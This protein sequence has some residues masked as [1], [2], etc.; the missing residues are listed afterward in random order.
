ML[1][2]GMLSVPPDISG[3]H[4]AREQTVEIM[5]DPEILGALYRRGRRR[6]RD[7]QSS[8]QATLKLDRLRGVL[9]VT[10]SQE[11]IADVRRQLECVSGSHMSVAAAVWAELMRTRADPDLNQAAIARIQHESGCRIHIERSAQQIQL[12]GPKDNS[13]I[14]EQLLEEL[15]RMCVEEVVDV[16]CPLD[17]G[18]LQKL[19]SFAQ[20]FGVTLQVGGNHVNILGIKG[21]VAEAAKELC[22]YDADELQMVLSI[23]R[24]KSSDAARLAIHTALASLA[25]DPEKKA[26][27]QSALGSSSPLVQNDTL[28]QADSLMQ[29]AVTVKMPPPYPVNSKGP[30]DQQMHNMQ[31]MEF[32]QGQMTCPTCGGGGNFCVHCG[33]PTEKM[34]MS[35]H[36]ACP[37]CGIVNFCA[38]CGQATAESAR[39]N[40]MSAPQQELPEAPSYQPYE[41]GMYQ[42]EMIPQRMPMQFVQPGV[43]HNGSQ[44]VM[45]QVAMCIPYD[46]SRQQGVPILAGMP[47]NNNQASPPMMAHAYNGVQAFWGA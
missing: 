32:Q 9:R 29:G 10:G 24:D 13:M 28:V 15:D 43:R 40:S 22:S 23:D 42:A 6:L 21:A 41:P 25:V 16:K 4:M 30:Y 14:A 18:F 11:S 33:K 19:Q 38:Y 35:P 39:M 12:F 37:T 5:L 46:A 44:Q 47:S 31:G 45:Y 1:T 7:I 2:G 34:M 36:A 17:P 8:S 27:I 20:E 3:E 26:F